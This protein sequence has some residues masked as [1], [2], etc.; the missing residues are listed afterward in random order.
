MHRCQWLNYFV[1]KKTLILTN[2]TKGY[3]I[4][5]CSPEIAALDYNSLNST[6]QIRCVFRNKIQDPL[7]I[8]WRYQLEKGER[9]AYDFEGQTM[10]PFKHEIVHIDGP[11]PQ[12]P[13]SIS[14]LTIRLLNS[15]YFT[16]YSIFSLKG[17]CFVNVKVNLKETGLITFLTWRT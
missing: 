6:L 5:R 2:L 9:M 11:F 17:N 14:I 16:N 3:P 1:K 12:V 10:S 7:D 15:S 4:T 13:H 8:V